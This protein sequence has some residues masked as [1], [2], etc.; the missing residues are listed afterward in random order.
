GRDDAGRRL[1][2]LSDR[3]REVA[4]LLAEGCSNAEVGARLHLTE[5]TVQ[6]YVSSALAKPDLQNRTQLAL[7]AARA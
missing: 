7:V 3:E 2:A 5:A 4:R 6:G 1:A